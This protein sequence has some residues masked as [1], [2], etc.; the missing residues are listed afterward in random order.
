[1]IRRVCCITAHF[2]VSSMGV[3]SGWMMFS[4][5]GVRPKIK[6]KLAFFFFFAYWITC[7]PSGGMEIT[8]LILSVHTS[9]N[10]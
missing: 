9:P 3:H 4:S 1:M 2:D 5:L 8:S 7:I 10:L 6:G